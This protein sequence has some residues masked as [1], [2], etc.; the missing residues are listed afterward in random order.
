MNY[1]INFKHISIQF[2]PVS[3]RI[4]RILAFLRALVSPLNT[5]QIDFF[6]VFLIEQRKI[7]KRNAQTLILENT[8]NLLFNPSG[9]PPIYI[10]NTG[11]DIS[12]AIMY[13]SF[14]NYPPIYFYNESESIPFYWYNLTETF[15][16]SDFK[17]YIPASVFIA[18]PIDL[19]RFEINKYRPAGKNYII[20]SY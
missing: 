5:L 1:N 14:E 2:V 12:G 10:D 17:V 3:K 20:I 11:D 18:F 4:P 9:I 6:N 8:L 19:I 7:V 13:N 15:Q 16:N